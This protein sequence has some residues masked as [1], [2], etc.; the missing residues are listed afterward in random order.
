MARE[1]EKEPEIFK[2]MQNSLAELNKKI[3]K[4][5]HAGQTGGMIR[6]M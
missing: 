3:E 1:N 2:N 6:I 4:V 5:E